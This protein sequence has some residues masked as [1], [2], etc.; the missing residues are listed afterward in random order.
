MGCDFSFFFF[1][2]SRSILGATKEA[3]PG[4]ASQ[5]A[6]AEPVPQTE[7]VEW[8]QRTDKDRA[9]VLNCLGPVATKVPTYLLE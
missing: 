3:Y 2:P 4:P 8:V 7:R 6:P 1:P 5:P 9:G